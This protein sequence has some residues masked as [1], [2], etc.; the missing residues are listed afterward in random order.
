MKKILWIAAVCVPLAASSFEVQFTSQGPVSPSQKAAP[1]GA[2]VEGAVVVPVVDLR[3]APEPVSPE[4]A[5]KQPYPIDPNQESQLLFGERVH[6]LELKKGWVRVEAV[7]QFE[8]T[9]ANRWQGYPGWVP[10]DAVIPRP[11]D[12]HSVA[13]VIVRYA[14]MGE[15]RKR[16]AAHQDLPMGARVAVIYTLKEWA[17]VQGP[18]G[19]MGWV[20]LRDLRMDRDAPSGSDAVRSA[21]LT[22]ARQFL[23][24]RYYWG[25]RSGHR[26]K[27]IV[28]SGVDCS[29][30]VNVS[31]R[32]V[33]LNA[34]RD[35]AEQHRLARPVENGG[36]LAAG[37]L[38][39]LANKSEPDRIVHVMIVDKK[40]TLL[41]ASHT[42]DRVRRISFSKRLGAK[43][44]N[45][46]S[47]DV[48]G[49]S[50]V[51]FGTFFNP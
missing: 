24:D 8:F 44:A 43:Q 28:P 42:A 29:G 17:R 7:D 48:C 40:E 47:G 22:A 34:P 9:H 25:G 50:V 49:E 26:K 18:S 27:G 37:D 36:D 35:A 10:Q 45:L 12:F 23:G 1:S 30:L 5:F 32:A 6:L 19:E 15:S 33:G 41:E 39:F 21:F 38:V 13:V 20:R 46:R 14:R 51:R 3:R 31:F 2:P 11:S 4:A 16:G